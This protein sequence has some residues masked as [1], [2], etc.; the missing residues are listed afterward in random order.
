[1]D[2]PRLNDEVDAVVG[3]EGPE[4][5][6]DT[7][8]LESH[9]SAPSVGPPAVAA[10][11]GLTGASGTGSPARTFP[12]RT[13]APRRRP[14]PLRTGPASSFTRGSGCVGGFDLEFAGGNLLLQ[15]GDL[16]LQLLRHIGGAVGQAHTLVGQVPDVGLTGEVVLQAQ[17]DGLE[18]TGPDLLD[19]RSEH[20]VGV[21]GGLGPVEIGRASCRERVG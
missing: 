3:N 17:L 4:A 15:R 16:V 19:H 7:S 9:K 11:A 8:K 10:G 6:G 1:M 12:A 18:H 2:L 21:V 13:R 20:D 5:F 14:G